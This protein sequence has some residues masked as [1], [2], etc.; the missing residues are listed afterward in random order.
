MPGCWLG[1]RIFLPTRRAVRSLREAFLRQSDGTAL[2]LPRLLPLGDLDEDALAIAGWEE[3]PGTGAAAIPPA[4]SGSPSS[5]PYPPRPAVRRGEITPDQAARLARELARLIDQIQTERLSY[6]G[7]AGL[8]PEEFAAHWQETLE[9]PANRH[10][11]MA[12]NSRRG[13]RH[14]SGRAPQ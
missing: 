10:R 7:L 6:D 11:S 4:I 1:Y 5:D 9:I 3:I 2:L 8:V 13:K 12:R 14:R